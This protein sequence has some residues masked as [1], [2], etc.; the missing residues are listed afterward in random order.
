MF[1]TQQKANSNTALI[2]NGCYIHNS[3]WKCEQRSTKEKNNATN[4]FFW[5]GIILACVNVIN[6]L[7]T[8]YTIL[9]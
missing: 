8:P 6:T 7:T 4:V 1:L 5:F 2:N 3:S 9:I